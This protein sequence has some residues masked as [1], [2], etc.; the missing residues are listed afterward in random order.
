MTCESPHKQE[1]AHLLGTKERECFQWGLVSRDWG[2]VMEAELTEREQWIRSM[3]ALVVSSSG[4]GRSGIMIMADFPR[5]VIGNR[6]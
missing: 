3:A 1:N 4:H 6:R 2:L 5:T